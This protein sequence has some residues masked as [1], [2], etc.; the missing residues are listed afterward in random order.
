MVERLH[1]QLK[2]SLKA[3]TTSSNWF[4]ELPMVLL[5]IRSSWRVNPNCSLA[6][7]V[8]SS[9]L[10]I[11]GEFL[12]PRD[13]KL[14]F[15]ESQAIP[16]QGV[17][18]NLDAAPGSVCGVG[19]VD[20]SVNILPGDHHITVAKI[21][22]SI[23]KFWI[24]YYGPATKRLEHYTDYCKKRMKSK[25]ESFWEYVPHTYLSEYW[26]ALHA[27][28]RSGALVLTDLHLETRPCSAY[29]PQ[30]KKAGTRVIATAPRGGARDDS[31]K[32]AGPVLEVT[33]NLQ[34]EIKD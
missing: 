23:G 10:R 17:N 25:Q 16:G 8:Y 3:R 18:L 28:M 27:F 4:A 21:F 29:P 26:D 6:E 9:T 1:R 33:N 22:Y 30:A 7:L 15:N 20:K 32:S 12:Q 11:P 24:P 5:G 13:V 2:T 34:S 19:I 31:T 14:E